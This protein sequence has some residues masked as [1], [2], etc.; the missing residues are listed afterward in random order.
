[1]KNG[2]R[3][4]NDSDLRHVGRAL[5]RAAAKAKSLA[6]ATG[7]PFYVWENGRIVDLLKNSRRKK[8]QSARRRA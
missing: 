8:P 2:K 5:R 1:M 4:I 3:S 6:R 7:T